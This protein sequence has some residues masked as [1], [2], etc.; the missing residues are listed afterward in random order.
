M[1]EVIP[2]LT[3]RPILD[4]DLDRVME[5]E[6]AAYPI[7][8][9]R[10][11][12]EDSLKA[13]SNDCLVAMVDGQICGHAVVS[14]VLDE[15]HLLNICIEPRF[16]GR[17]LGRVFLRKLIDLAVERGS[18]SFYLEVRVSNEAAIKLYFSEGFN[19]V[20]LRPNY[21]PAKTGREDA[22]LMTL[23]LSI[24]QYV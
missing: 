6:N 10:G 23:E 5:V 11:V 22:M 20:G 3:F 2:S 13:K 17:G 8:W 21:Y 1:R 4:Q 16:A 19:E 15:T 12:F 24:D 9:T 7:P 14:H 18:N